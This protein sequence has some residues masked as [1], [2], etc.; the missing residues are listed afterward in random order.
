M[1]RSVSMMSK[2]SAK[3]AGSNKKGSSKPKLKRNVSKRLH[4]EEKK[5]EAKLGP[6]L[7]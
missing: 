2:S 4:E 6:M 3:S 7:Y 1:K 5:E